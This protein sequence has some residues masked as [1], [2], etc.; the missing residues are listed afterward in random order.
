MDAKQELKE[1]ILSIRRKYRNET[2]PVMKDRL[3]HTHARLITQYR[4]LYG[5]IVD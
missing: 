1:Q 3:S 5:E 2:D 4:S